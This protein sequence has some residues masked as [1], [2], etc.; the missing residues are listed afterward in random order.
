MPRITYFLYY[1]R[2]LFLHERLS[3][4][5]DLNRIGV[6]HI[7][8]DTKENR[9]IPGGMSAAMGKYTPNHNSRANAGPVVVDSHVSQL[10]DDIDNY[11][12]VFPRKTRPGFHNFNL[13]FPFKMVNLYRYKPIHEC[14]L[15][16]VYTGILLRVRGEDGAEIGM[17]FKVAAAVPAPFR[18]A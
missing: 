1:V 15:C 7:L 10:P 4:T 11:F 12:C 17:Y 5:G 8:T 18:C 6:E 9:I 14:V 3:I 13:C 2:N 16:L